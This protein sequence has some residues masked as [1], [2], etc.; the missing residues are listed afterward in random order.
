MYKLHKEVLY[1]ADAYEVIRYY[2]NLTAKNSLPD[3]P[4]DCKSNLL[5]L[6]AGKNADENDYWLYCQDGLYYAVQIG[7]KSKIYIGRAVCIPYAAPIAFA[8][9]RI[10]LKNCKWQLGV[11][12]R[13]YG[14]FMYSAAGLEHIALMLEGKNVDVENFDESVWSARVEYEPKEHHLEGYD[15]IH[16]HKGSWYDVWFSL[17]KHGPIFDKEEA[18]RLPINAHERWWNG[19]KI[20]RQ[21]RKD[22]H[23]SLNDML[24][25]WDIF[26]KN[27]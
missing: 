26:R 5:K 8:Y 17:A 20:I 22:E 11:P 27:V 14:Y 3:G 6:A 7:L 16:G 19:E 10:P 23:P 2:V 1:E 9:L 13:L 15:E 25:I 21:F 4:Y 12:S 18:D 24:V